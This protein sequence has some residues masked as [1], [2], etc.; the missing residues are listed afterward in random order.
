MH[1][2]QDF[3]FEKEESGSQK[4]L[5][6]DATNKSNGKIPVVKAN[7]I[8]PFQYALRKVEDYHV[9]VIGDDI[10]T[11][12]VDEF[13]YYELTKTRLAKIFENLQMDR[14]DG[15]SWE[16]SNNSESKKIWITQNLT[17]SKVESVD[18]V[19]FQLGENYE[20]ENIENDINELINQVKKYSPS[21]E[22]VWIGGW[23]KNEILLNALPRICEKNNIGLI[24][25][26]DLNE[27]D[28]R[29]V[30]KSLDETEVNIEE[31][32]EL[33]DEIKYYP[34]H[35]AMQIISNRIVEILKFNMY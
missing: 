2:G 12:L 9:L 29:T 19:I 3:S 32:N 28:Y 8:L 16:K 13:H 7:L 21:A 22:I 5:V 11:N 6:Q 4:A 17:A 23:N 10:T 24:K 18:L 35:E 14:L 26:D 27:E 15:S 33:E 34:N 1:L 31:N 30:I 20:G 25:I